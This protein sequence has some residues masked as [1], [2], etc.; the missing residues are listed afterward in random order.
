[1]AWFEFND[2]NTERAKTIYQS[3]HNL[4]QNPDFKEILGWLREGLREEQKT[5]PGL[6]QDV[7][8]RWNQGRTQVLN[9]VIGANDNAEKILIM[10]LKQQQ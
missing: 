1:M 4:R 8:L 3:F 9:A 7:K 2:G 5:N 6:E 10:L